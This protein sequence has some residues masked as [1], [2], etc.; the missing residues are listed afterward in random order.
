MFFSIKYLFWL[1][2]CWRHHICFLIYWK[3]FW[4]S[5]PFSFF[6]AWEWS[7]ISGGTNGQMVGKC[8]V[9]PAC[10]HQQTGISY[11]VLDSFKYHWEDWRNRPS[12]ASRKVS[13]GH[14]PAVGTR[15]AIGPASIVKLTEELGRQPWSGWHNSVSVRV[16]TSKLEAS[17][18]AL[19]PT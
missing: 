12:W 3:S 16:H 11:W 14:I 6:A 5:P 7:R 4:W 8:P 1:N 2:G 9:T 17:C 18:P 13:Q 19:T 10:V 15:E